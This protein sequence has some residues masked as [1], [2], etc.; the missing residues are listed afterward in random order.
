MPDF[1]TSM[2]EPRRSERSRKSRLT[3]VDGHPVLRLNTYTLEEGEPS[4]FRETGGNDLFSASKP[5]KKRKVGNLCKKGEKQ[6]RKNE[7]AWASNN[8]KINEDSKVARNRAMVFM[9]SVLDILQPFITTDVQRKLRELVEKLPF[10][11]PL[12]K[13]QISRQ[14]KCII[15]GEMRDYQLEGLSFLVSMFD[16][17]LSA[18][19]ADEMGLGKTLQTIAFLGYLKFERYVEG[20]HLVVCPLSVL[21]SWMREFKHWCPELRVIRLHSSDKAE[22]ERFRREVLNKSSSFDVV[23]TTYE[24]VFSQNMKMIL[25]SKIHWRYLVLDEGHKI[26]NENALISDAVRHINRQGLLLL[27]G[28]PL[29]NN[30]HELWALFNQ[31]FPEIFTDAKLFDNIYSLSQSTCDYKTLDKAHLLLKTL[32]LRRLKV[33]VE[34]SLPPRSELKIFSPLSKMQHFWYR[35]LLMKNSKVL[36]QLETEAAGIFGRNK[37]GDAWKK[38]QSLLMQLRKCANHPYLFPGAQDDP[39]TVGDDIITASGKMQLLDRLLHKLQSN[40]HRV[41]LFSQFTTMLNILEDYCQ[42]RGFDYRRLDGSTNRVRRTIDMHMFNKP[43]SPIFIFLLSTRA[44]GLGINLQTADTVILFDSDWNP[45]VDLQAMARVHRI[46]Q[47]KPVH[48]YRLITAGTVEERIQQRS[49]KKLFLDHAVN[50]GGLG[51]NEDTGASSLSELLSTITFGA[52]AFISSEDAVELTDED[53]NKILDRSSS[54]AAEGEIGKQECSKVRQTE[55]TVLDSFTAIRVFEGIDYTRIS[56]R[57]IGEEWIEATKRKRVSTTVNVDG[58][59]ILRQNLYDLEE[60]E[61]SVFG[62]ECSKDSKEF[63]STKRRLQRA[64]VDYEHDDACL[65]CKDGGLL[66]CCDGCPAAYHAECLGYAEA[67]VAKLSKLKW[68]CPHH[69]CGVCGRKAAAVGGL[70]FRCEMCPNAYCEDDLPAEAELVGNCEH[71]QNLGQV[72][73]SQAYFIHCCSYCGYLATLQPNATTELQGPAERGGNQLGYT[74]EGSLSKVASHAGV[75]FKAVE[76]VEKEDI[77]TMALGH[78]VESQNSAKG[79]LLS[80]YHESKQ[81]V[82]ELPEPKP[83]LDTVKQLNLPL[84]EMHETKP[85]LCDLHESKP[86]LK[87]LMGVKNGTNWSSLKEIVIID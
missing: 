79:G 36:I 62:R 50:N 60:G 33:D 45:Q 12:P 8:H 9:L 4:V 25:R 69:S 2:E 44:G 66:I 75:E 21:S 22:R 58:Y 43:S 10:K 57:D 15:N 11:Q 38:L 16:N 29:Q 3:F 59:C 74:S 41:V 82:K 54:P 65:L 7:N 53:L 68:L 83:S 24:M 42:F 28:T 72:H 35:R 46:G 40:G 20:P 34:K 84:D 47:T 81:C 78:A 80:H 73:P 32:C 63:K 51:Q 31:L 23:V 14:P 37:D 52:K 19:L 77:P 30:L 17:G 1:G 49:E 39:D 64:G 71:F 86:S 55:S 6:D 5:A 76:K 70:L 26:K 56:K 13:T 18:I 67:E 87:T 48:V 85:S 61:P 27:T